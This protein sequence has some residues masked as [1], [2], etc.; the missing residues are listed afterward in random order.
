MRRH[1]KP[2]LEAGLSDRV[3]SPFHTCCFNT[4]S[5]HGYC[6][7]GSVLGGEHRGQEE[8]LSWSQQSEAH[9]MYMCVC[10]WR[11]NAVHALMP[12]TQPLAS[13]TPEYTYVS[14]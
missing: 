14:Y 5:R 11:G 4:C 10:T 3:T 2:S 7:L 1:Q 6:V 8:A 12:S 13:H 9:T